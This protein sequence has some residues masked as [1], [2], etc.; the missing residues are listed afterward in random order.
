MAS[1]ISAE[2][3]HISWASAILWVARWA[4]VILFKNSPPLEYVLMKGCTIFKMLS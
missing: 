2:M 3:F 4:Y 1:H